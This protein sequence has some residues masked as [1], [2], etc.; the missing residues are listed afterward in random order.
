MVW[1]DA[2][3]EF[4]KKQGVRSRARLGD[5]V[6]FRDVQFLSDVIHKN[7]SF[8]FFFFTNHFVTAASKQLLLL[9]TI[10]KQM[11]PSKGN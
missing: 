10:K 7:S 8:T 3:K 5:T 11:V 4:E 2:G 1:R 6:K 9:E